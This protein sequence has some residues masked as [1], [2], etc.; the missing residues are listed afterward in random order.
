M[1]E[2]KTPTQKA[3]D[4]NPVVTGTPTGPDYPE[5]THPAVTASSTTHSATNWEYRDLPDDRKPDPSTVAEEQIL[6]GNEASAGGVVA[7]SNA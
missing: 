5:G 1:A 7:L 3:A 4:K 2:K 6:T